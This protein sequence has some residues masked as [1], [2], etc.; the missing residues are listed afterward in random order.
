MSMNGRQSMHDR[1]REKTTQGAGRTHGMTLLE[2][3]LALT[4]TAFVLASI[5][6][7]IDLHLRM[8]DARR[9]DV[10]QVQVARAVLRIIAN[11]LRSTVQPNTTDFSSLTAMATKAM[12]SGGGSVAGLE[13]ALGSGSDAGSG[14]DMTAPGGSEPGDLGGET[15]LDLAGLGTDMTAT[16]ST[17][18]VGIASMETSPPVPGL[19]GNQFELQMDVSRLPRVDEMQRMA[20]ASTAGPLVDIPSDVKTVAYFYHDPNNAMSTGDF[21]DAAGNPQA[22][23][24][25]RVL[26]R[27]VTVYASDNASVTSVQ[28]MGE[29]IAPEIAGIQFEYFDGMEWL[30]EWDS[31]LQEALP[32]AVRITV[33][34]QPKGSEQLGVN[35]QSSL[36]SV[37]QLALDSDVQTYSLTVRLPTALPAEAMSTTEESGLEAVGL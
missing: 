15:D 8:L 6:M 21:R 1:R 36:M 3:M 16:E 35:L 25:R 23:L 31:D 22:G 2:V 11:D 20:V 33:V 12:A 9:N 32:L 30:P 34:M 5:S 13:D 29:I 19:Y 10:E 28:N 17:A 24:V 18:S 4:L 37:D 27:A 26:D 7:A 14:S